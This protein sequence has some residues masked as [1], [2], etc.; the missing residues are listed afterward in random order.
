MRHHLTLAAVDV[1]RRFLPI[2]HIEHQ[3]EIGVA[4]DLFFAAEIERM[5]VGEIQSCVNVEHRGA[6]GFGERHQIVEAVR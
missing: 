6:D 3:D 2:A 1:V 4:E 5:A